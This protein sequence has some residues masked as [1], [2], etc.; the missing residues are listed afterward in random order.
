MNKAPIKKV[1]TAKVNQE[2]PQV[3]VPTTNEE[4]EVHMEKPWTIV[5]KHK[6]GKEPAIGKTNIAQEVIILNCQN[7]FDFL[8]GEGTS[9]ILVL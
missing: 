3:I 8:G 4:P 2:V 5:G 1:W 7:G 6:K 9:D